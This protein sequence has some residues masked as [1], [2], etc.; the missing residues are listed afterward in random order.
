MFFQFE[1]AFPHSNFYK[2]TR[3]LLSTENLYFALSLCLSLY[4]SLVFRLH[5]LSFSSDFLRSTT[6]NSIENSEFE[7]IFS[8]KEV[9]KGFELERI[10]IVKS[11]CPCSF[12]RDDDSS[13]W[14]DDGHVPLF[15][16]A[17]G[18]RVSAF[19]SL[20]VCACVC[21]CIHQFSL[22][23]LNSSQNFDTKPKNRSIRYQK[24]NGRIQTFHSIHR[25]QEVLHLHPEDFHPED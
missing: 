12:S 25:L 17:K 22:Q 24:Q 23:F 19:C 5:R 2:G 6:N 9:L 13:F 4:F 20:C 8:L 21:C 15:S 14:C 7:L 11:L 10:S 1:L 16:R 18:R 3:A